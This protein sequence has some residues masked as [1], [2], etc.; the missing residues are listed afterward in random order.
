MKFTAENNINQ[1]N[2]CCFS[3]HRIVKSEDIDNIINNLDRILETLYNNGI[4]NFISGGALG[5]DTLAAESVIK[6]RSQY[7]DI[8]LILALPCKDQASKWN[9]IQKT[10]YTKLLGSADE[11]VYV[12]DNYTP[13]CMHKR[14]RFMVDNSS[15][16][17][18][19]ILSMSSGT[20]Y[21]TN[22]ALD[23]GHCRIINVLTGDFED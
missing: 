4:T 20:A 15:V 2:T 8:K 7:S 16:I 23:S 14:N 18:V 13:E 21:T 6:L 12:S 19:Y 17:I 5:F 3:G 22:Y 10:Q 9:K 11:V 1:K